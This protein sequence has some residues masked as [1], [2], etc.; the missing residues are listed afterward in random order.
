MIRG[1]PRGRDLLPVERPGRL[2]GDQRHFLLA[3]ALGDVDEHDQFLR[4]AAR[5]RFQWPDFLAADGEPGRCARQLSAGLGRMVA[6][7]F[8]AIP[9]RP[10]RFPAA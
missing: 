6:G 10:A 9:S 7:V 8:S 1:H 3:A 4:R 2:Y 5:R